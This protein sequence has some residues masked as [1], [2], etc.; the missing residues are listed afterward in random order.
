MIE[1]MIPAILMIG[2]KISKI[3]AVVLSLRGLGP[4]AAV[5]VEAPDFEG[6]ARL[7]EVGVEL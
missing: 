4:G 3:K 5:L 7:E 2:P 6:A 1:T